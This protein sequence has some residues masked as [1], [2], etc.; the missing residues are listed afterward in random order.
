MIVSEDFLRAKEIGARYF[1]ERGWEACS[2][3]VSSGQAIEK[4]LELR[5]DL[6]ILDA[7]SA[8][9]RCARV[10]DEIRRAAPSIKICL[11]SLYL[12]GRDALSPD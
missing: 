6:V 9:V 12:L 8:T 3:T 7:S 11:F 2:E 10:A 1:E 4:I 5:P